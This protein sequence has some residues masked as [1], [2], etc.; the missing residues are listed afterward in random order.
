MKARRRSIHALFALS[1]ALLAALLPLGAGRGD[2][3]DARATTQRAQGFLPSRDG[4]QFRNTFK[5]SPLPAIL[6]NAESG[7]L[8]LVR[9]G[10]SDGLPKEYGLCGGMSLAAADFYLSRSAMPEN[11]KA[12]AQGSALYEYLYQRQTDSMG[13]LGVMV[14]KFWRWMDLPDRS[15]AGES[16]YGLS[17]QELPILV[18][19]LKA[20]Q[21]VP[22]GL[23]YS[24]REA[25]G[26]LWENHQ[27]LAYSVVEKDGGVVEF[28]IYDPN[29]PKDDECVVRVRPVGK[30]KKAPLEV[31]AE[32]VN[33]KGAVKRVRG[34]FAM[35]YEPRVPDAKLIG[36]RAAGKAKAGEVAPGRGA[37]G[38]A[39]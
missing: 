5:G 23:V 31:S 14:M 16:T 7:P 27:V 20:R 6:R 19:R 30:E 38:V 24:S 2:K 4:F 13:S 21:L 3:K 34:F 37:P 32:R 12:P 29:F 36:K 25:G 10:V 15:P 11:G 26:K 8:S 18:K 39:R 33:G 1:L 28:K 22:M 35:P 17:A 9:S